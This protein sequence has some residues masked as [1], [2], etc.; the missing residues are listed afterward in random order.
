MKKV[1]YFSEWNT[2]PS[3]GIS[4]RTNVEVGREPMTDKRRYHSEMDHPNIRSLNQNRNSCYRV[5]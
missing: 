3:P 5:L 4:L 2:T 1:L